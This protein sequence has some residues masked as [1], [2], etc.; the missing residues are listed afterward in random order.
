MECPAADRFL[1]LLEK[2]RTV[3]TSLTVDILKAHIDS[4]ASQDAVM[5]NFPTMKDIEVFRLEQRIMSR[6][7]K[8]S[9]PKVDAQNPL[10]HL[11]LSELE[12]V[13][14]PRYLRS[15]KGFERDKQNEE[16]IYNEISTRLSAPENKSGSYIDKLKK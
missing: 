1:E 5:T 6:K 14:I 15:Y 11:L 12:F 13:T 8:L 7:L 9:V 2:S 10:F 4:C 16:R 3:F